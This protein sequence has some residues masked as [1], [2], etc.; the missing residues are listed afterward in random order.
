MFPDDLKVAAKRW[1]VETRPDGT[2]VFDDVALVLFCFI[3]VWE[4]RQACARLALSAGHPDLSD[5]IAGRVL[6]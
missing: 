6:E 4:E 3:W 1:A 5:A 2:F